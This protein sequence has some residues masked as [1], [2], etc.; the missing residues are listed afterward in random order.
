[1]KCGKCGSMNSAK[2]GY[3]H[4]KQRC[5][6]KG[7]G[8]QFAQTGGKNAAKRAFA[9][10][11]YV[12]GLSMNAIALMF[13]AQAS[14]ALYRVKNF[15]LKAYEKPAPQGDAAVGLDG[16]RHFLEPKKLKCGYGRHSAAEHAYDR[17]GRFPFCPFSCQRFTG[18]DTAPLL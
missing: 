2:A 13:G 10:Y 6:C 12:A 17:L 18:R 11:L 15:A 8:R 5:K 16:M 9:L 4:G 14:T 7:R 1:M 3:N